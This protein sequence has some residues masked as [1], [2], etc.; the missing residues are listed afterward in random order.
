MYTKILKKVSLFANFPDNALEDLG[1]V[2]ERKRLPAGSILFRQGDEG[3]ALYIVEQ[4]SV[5]IYSQAETGEEVIFAHLNSGDYFGEMSLIENKPRSASARTTEDSELLILSQEDFLEVLNANPSLGIKLASEFSAR[6]RSTSS[7]ITTGEFKPLTPSST[8][9]EKIRVFISY[10]RRD[11][12]FVQKLHSGLTDAG[13]E[14]WVDWEGIPLATDWW[15]E[16]EEAIEQSDAFIFVI[17]PDSVQSKYC[18]QE[19]KT[20]LRHNKRLVPVLFRQG[21]DTIGRL[22]PELQAINFIFMRDDRE[23]ERRLPELVNLLHTDMAYVKQHT[24][25]QERAIEWDRRRRR[26]S[27]VLQ[28]EDLDD[29]E[30]WLINAMNK[31]PKPTQLQIDY[32]QGSRLEAK[33]RQRRFVMRLTVALAIMLVLTIISI[34]SFIAARQS[35]QAE[36]AALQVA[37]T[38]EAI[39][40]EA[41][42][43]AIAAKDEAESQRATA[44]A[45]Q[46]TAVNQKEEADN[47]RDAA[48]AAQAEAIRQRSIA[49]EQRRD[50]EAQRLA[51]QAEQD[52]LRG[53]LLNR[54]ILLAISSLEKKPNFQGDL[55]LRQGLDLLPRL[56]DQIENNNPVTEVLFSPDGKYLAIGDTSGLI[57]IRD[58]T[59]WQEV[60]RLEGHKGSILDLAFTPSGARLVSAGMDGT[61]RLW[62]M[63]NGQELAVF[64][65]DGPVRAVK[66]SPVGDW[67]ATGSDDGTAR[68]WNPRTG[69]QIALVVH[70]GPVQDVSFSPGGSFVAS[71]SSD[72]VVTVWSPTTGEI[73]VRLPLAAEV[74]VV[75]FSP[76]YVWLA[77]GTA[78]GSVIIWEPTSRSKITQFSHEKAVTDIAFSPDGNWLVTTGEDRS[79]RIWETRTGQPI[80]L[81]FHDRPVV[82]ATFSPDGA[83]V[84]TA[85]EDNTVRVWDPLTGQE[86]ARM[87]HP[88]PVNSVDFTRDSRLLVTGGQR[89]GVKIWTPQ[90]IGYTLVDLVVD[91]EVIAL[92]FG[93]DQKRIATASTD[94]ILRIWDISEGARILVNIESDSPILDVDFSQDGELIAAAT[95]DNLAI[96]WDASTGEEIARFEHDG[97]VNDVEFSAD[98]AWL[99]TASQD[100]TARVWVLSS[101][102]EFRRFVHGGAV[103]SVSLYPDRERLATAS[104]D[105]TARIWNISSGQ[106]VFILEHTSSVILARYVAAKNWLVTISRP[107]VMRVWNAPTGTLLERFVN[108]SEILAVAI[109]E[110]GSRLA[111]SDE[112][113]AVRIWDFEAGLE[114]RQEIARIPYGNMVN[115]VAFAPQGN[116]IA[117]SGSDNHVL[118]SLLLFDDLKDRACGLLQRNLTL[119][120]WEQFFADEL[121][122][123]ICESLPP[124]PRAVTSLKKQA[125]RL[126]A[127]GQTEAAIDL[128]SYILEIDPSQDFDVTEELQSLII[129]ALLEQGLEYALAGEFNA[130][131]ESYTRLTNEYANVLNEQ[132]RFAEFLAAMCRVGG[133]A[134][135]AASAL[136]LCDA[137]IARDPGNGSIYDSRGRVRSWLGDF[138]G[139]IDDFEFAMAWKLA[140]QEVDQRAV[141]LF[142]QEREQW[143]ATLKSG[144]NP[145]EN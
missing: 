98:G 106:P 136:P 123:P 114:L 45:A 82:D 111:I 70:G 108:D 52:L 50:A 28:G 14:T 37:V 67:I 131:L 105:G 91:S 56:V 6:L 99:A 126:G 87:V 73:F 102:Q 29:A 76:I 129:G 79:A 58:A 53:S 120:E 137:A 95:A 124:D 71:G 138:N 121:Y 119:D 134:E 74:T 33:K 63:S 92:D 142:V 12:E 34:I 22:I 107:N 101:G 11:K 143:I 72:R 46:A 60:F 97:P 89:E 65:H 110:D 69:R 68:T 18:I 104:D 118:I 94:R 64:E 145:F 40:R 141:Q 43:T 59:T 48:M 88:A 117:S 1:K 32:I 85:S 140:D 42:A 54:S 51:S 100:G 17:S 109:S 83:W 81:L 15:A 21:E 113:M 130:A 41:E 78:D 128:L 31:E 36:R 103:W 4:G 24:R 20:A 10:S 26:S 44:V 2:M 49:E 80:A 66:I 96:I 8:T 139:A 61:A 93:P 62:D 75:E 7:A 116:L 90:S 16:I 125:G 39:A 27:M 127:T 132:A 57:Q 55:A 144:A 13:V 133:T 84:A 135:N 23:F 30:Q 47:A 122:R 25:F 35:Q 77:T 9:K 3:D 19:I 112:D 5:V 38:N 115:A 86:M